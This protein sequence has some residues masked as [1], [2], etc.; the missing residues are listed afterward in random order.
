M[1][2][3]MSAVVNC[4]YRTGYRILFAFAVVSACAPVQP[5][6][7]PVVPTS[8][9]A[10]AP[11]AT[12]VM[13]LLSPTHLSSTD[14]SKGQ[15][16]HRLSAVSPVVIFRR[17]GDEY[18]PAG[19]LEAG[20]AVGVIESKQGDYWPETWFKITCPDGMTDP[21]WVLW[22][23]NALYSYEGSPVNLEIPDPR[24]LKIESTN[25]TTSPDKRWR[26]VVSQT[27]TA[28]LGVDETRF[29]HVELKVTSL[30]DGTIWTPVSEW[31][32][33]GPG[34]EYAPQPFHWS[35]DGHYLYY[36]NPFDHHGPFCVSMTIS[37]KTGAICSG[38]GGFLSLGIIFLN[39]YAS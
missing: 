15:I 2:A 35:Q 25:Q 22:D 34:Q 36:S 10:A 17:P 21:C 30:Q 24:S 1:Q 11:T 26:A 16:T 39:I 33:A 19:T 37:A 31:H 12:A 7:I 28:T 9:A 6:K 3:L 32:A 27:E 8:T 23:F 18:P 5:A 29:F 4:A 13:P 38:I 14:V 20:V